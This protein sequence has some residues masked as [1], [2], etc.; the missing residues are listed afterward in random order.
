M[1]KLF[2]LIAFLMV[3][4]GAKA[5]WVMIHRVDYSAFT[6]FPAY[7]MGYVPEWVD[8]VMTD[9]GGNYRHAT[10][11][12]M[13]GDGALKEGEEVVGTVTKNDGTVYNKIY[14]GGTWHQY[15][16]TNGNFPTELD[17]AYTLRA[18]ARAS[19]PVSVPVQMRWSWSADPVVSTLNIGTEWQEY[20]CDFTG[21][22]GTACDLIAQPNT[23]ATIEWKY[24]EVWQ[25]K[26]ASRPVQW[27]NMLVDENTGEYYDGIVNQLAKP[28]EV[29]LAGATADEIFAL[30]KPSPTKVEGGDIV[31]YFQSPAVDKDGYSAAADQNSFA[32]AN[33]L[34]ITSPEKIKKGETIRISF[35]C[36][37]D[38]SAPTDT[39]AHGRPSAYHHWQAIGEVVFTPEWVHIEKTLDVTEDHAKDEGMYSLAFNLTKENC[40]A[41]TWY[42]KNIKMEKMVLDEGYFVASQNAEK[43]ITY[44]LD[45]ATEMVYDE[46]VDALVAVVGEK[47]KQDTWIN[48]IMISTK[49]G[50]DAA[51]KANT[52]K[53]AYV[54]NDAEDWAGYDAATNY[55]I[56]L[57][58]AGVWQIAIAPEDGLI[59][60]VKLE[61][62]KDKE[63]LPE[64]ANPTEVIV[65]ATAKGE[66]NPW[67]NQFFLLANRELKVGE[68]V[69]VKFE[70]KAATEAPVGSQSTKGLGEY[71]SGAWPTFT[72]TT[73]YQQFNETYTIS[74]EGH[75]SFTFNLSEFADANTYYFKNFVF[76]TEDKTERL[77]NTEGTTQLWVKEGAGT[78]AY[79]Y[80]TDPS[81]I[82]S[83][84]N[85]AS[86]SKAV[87]NI[88][89]QRVSNNYKG[90]VVKNGSKYIVK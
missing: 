45:V 70:Y 23:A 1:K 33:Q 11:A 14:T 74:K 24:I 69:V 59:N 87:Y 31:Y 8:G 15:F 58:A 64:I 27:R 28:L 68:V 61:G 22:Q 85:N 5:E 65:H 13:E 60:F 41:N 53:P 3:V 72:A 71:L 20:E 49:R 9:V 76:M 18:M 47:G 67:D 10:D 37:A 16:I 39:Q 86:T 55:K 26:K 84:V 54:K 17:G 80:G 6:G 50:Q 12:E 63:P 46:N 40:E 90:I 29:E 4:M 43:G 30:V 75:S 7:V 81:G 79:E 34:F 62:E 21:V 44:D 52:I 38:K 56:K 48:E 78:S 77:M 25:N 36:K 89:G 82:S 2:T 73:E 88:A 19:E 57:P 66:G 32:W 83:V 35:D 51:F 42:L